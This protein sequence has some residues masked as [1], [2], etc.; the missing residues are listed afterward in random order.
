ME[1][2]MAIK[3]VYVVC[4][5]NVYSDM[6][7]EPGKSTADR[8]NRKR[9]RHA[10]G[11]TAQHAE[12]LAFNRFAK[13]MEYNWYPATLLGEFQTKLDQDG[14]EVVDVDLLTCPH[15]GKAF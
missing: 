15:C 1:V 2:A 14:R 4:I 11:F 9:T 8:E 5:F 3:P 13:L 12:D 6:P 7:D 10:V